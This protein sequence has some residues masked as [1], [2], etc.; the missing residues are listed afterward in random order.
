MEAMQLSRNLFQIWDM[1]LSKK[2]T[3]LKDKRGVSERTIARALKEMVPDIGASPTTVNRWLTGEG[4][5]NLEQAVAL[6]AYFTVPLS[7]L[8]YESA[9][10]APGELPADEAAVLRYY[11]SKKMKGEIDEDDAI[12]GMASMLRRDVSSSGESKGLEFRAT[13]SKR[14]N[15]KSS[16]A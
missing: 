10:A 6:A 1:E 14:S 5:P 7:Y 12:T 16:G 9:E 13:G 11:R 3:Q 2:L 15:P 8:A 4:I